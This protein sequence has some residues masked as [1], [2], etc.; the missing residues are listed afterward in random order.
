MREIPLTQGKFALVD[1]EDYDRL[2]AMGKWYFRHG[3]AVKNIYERI[4]GKK[5]WRNVHMHRVVANT[6]F[7]MFT[8]HINRN[9]LDNRK[10]NLRFCTFEEN[11]RNKIKYSNNTSDYKGVTWHK[12]T[13]KWH[14]QLQI[15]NKRLHLGD[16]I[17]KHEAARAYNAAALKHHGQFARLNEIQ[18]LS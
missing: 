9:G 17:C 11:M 8:D 18:E 2:V 13:K 3:Y 4:N 15:K 7:G 10:V 1:D 14:A 12:G 6:P 5:T 16:F